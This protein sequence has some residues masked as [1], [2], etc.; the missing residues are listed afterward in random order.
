MK[1]Q[2]KSWQS[3]NMLIVYLSRTNNTRVVAEIIH[4][5]ENSNG[6]LPPPSK[7]F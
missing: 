5:T 6:I 7:A 1:L 2:P 3:K 4:K